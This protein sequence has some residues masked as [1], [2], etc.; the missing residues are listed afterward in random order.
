MISFC[1]CLVLSEAIGGIRD[2]GTGVSGSCE[3]LRGYWE[4]NLGSL[5]DL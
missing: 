3:P 2:T 5:E 4:S 1:V